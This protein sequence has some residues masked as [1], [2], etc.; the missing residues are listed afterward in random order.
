MRI[1]MTL[2]YDGSGYA[3]W[4]RQNNALGIETIVR[5]ALER[6]HHYPVEV[7]ASGRT[8]GGVHALAQVIHFDSEITM[9]NEH[10][11]RAMNALLPLD[12]RVQDAQPAEDT[13]HARFDAVRK[14]Y[15]YLVSYADNDPFAYKYHALY[16]GR[17]DVARMQRCGD[18]LIGTHDFTSFTSARIDPRKSRVRTLYCCKV[19][20]EANGVRFQLEGNSFLRY[21]VRMIVGTLIEA[22]RGRLDEADVKAILEA[23]DKHACR[24]K[25]VANGLYLVKVWYGESEEDR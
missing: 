25:A 4:Q 18:V 13:F 7:T 9:G 12:I 8:D 2:A 19:I 21:M 16:H 3:G 17:L 11:V 10:W 6:L 23:K 5:E 24:Y 14:R 1:K 20:E 15:D 22:G